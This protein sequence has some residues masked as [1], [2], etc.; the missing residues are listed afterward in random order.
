MSLVKYTK[1]KRK[2]GEMFLP[3]FN[4]FIA[5][6]GLLA[7]FATGPIIILVSAV[8][9]PIRTG[10]GGLLATYM[11]PLAYALLALILLAFWF[12]TGLAPA[13]RLPERERRYQFGHWL[14]AITSIATAAAFAFPFVLAHTSGKHNLV[15]LAWLALPVYSFGF[16]IWAG[17]LYMIWSSRA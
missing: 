7:M 4:V 17:G 12:K 16:L 2:W 6:F 8:L 3:N 13:K 11:F 10:Q 14:V 9:T 5:C 15:M 1:D